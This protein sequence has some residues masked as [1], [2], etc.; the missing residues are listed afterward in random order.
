LDARSTSSA[1]ATSVTMPAHQMVKAIP[2]SSMAWSQGSEWGCQRCEAS[3]P[4]PWVDE[5][6]ALSHD[7][8]RP[9][10]LAK[11]GRLNGE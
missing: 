8:A 10:V 3:L 6:L 2:G 1:T 9:A 7:S 11:P 5:F 4:A